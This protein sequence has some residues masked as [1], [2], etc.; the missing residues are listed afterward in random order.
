MKEDGMAKN[1]SIYYGWLTEYW[2][3]LNL[4]ERS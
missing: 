1:G 4:F 2:L 3:L